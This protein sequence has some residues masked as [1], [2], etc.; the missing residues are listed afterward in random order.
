MHSYIRKIAIA[1]WKWIFA[2][3]IYILSLLD[4]DMAAIMIRNYCYIIRESFI[5][6]IIITRLDM[7]VIFNGFVPLHVDIS[8]ENCTH[9]VPKPLVDKEKNLGLYYKFEFSVIH[10]HKLQSMVTFSF[11]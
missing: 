10:S 7:N 2:S 11:K 8:H 5:S 4:A 6:T 3:I 1:I 9:S